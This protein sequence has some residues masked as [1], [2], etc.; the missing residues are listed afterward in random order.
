MKTLCIA[1]SKSEMAGSANGA[2][3]KRNFSRFLLISLIGA[4]L[5][6]SDQRHCHSVENVR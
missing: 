4:T 3:L 2:V 6:S 5:Q 1:G